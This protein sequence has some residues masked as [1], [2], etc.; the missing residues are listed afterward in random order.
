MNLLF[1]NII[2]I[3]NFYMGGKTYAVKI[4]KNPFGGDYNPNQWPEEIWKED[5]TY[6]KEAHINSATINVF[7]GQRYSRQKMCMIFH[8]LTRS[9]ICFQ[10]KITILSWQ[11]L[12]QALPAWMVK[13]ISGDNEHRL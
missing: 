7:H 10:M 3:Y 13:E 5:M 1:K 4:Q 2:K 9:L 12:Q 6:F 8:S 11:H